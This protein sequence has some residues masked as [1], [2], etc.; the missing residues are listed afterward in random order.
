VTCLFSEN[1]F[2]LKALL[3]TGA[4]DN[5]IRSAIET[6]WQGRRDRYSEERLEALHSADG[7]QAKSH[8]K[9]EMIRLG[10]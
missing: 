7:Y 1:G 3:R 2:D 5:E 6:V 10:G 4:G 8:Q 9:I